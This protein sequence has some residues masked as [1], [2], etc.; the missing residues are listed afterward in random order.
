MERVG[1]VGVDDAGRPFRDDT[2]GQQA[3]E[4]REHDEVLFFQYLLAMRY[5]GN[6]YISLEKGTNSDSFYM[7][8]I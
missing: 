6:H 4:A 2:G 1:G 5:K 3:H 8:Q 7:S